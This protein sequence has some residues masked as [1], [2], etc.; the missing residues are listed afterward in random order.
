MK[1]VLY[2]EEYI[3]YLQ[4]KRYKCLSKLGRVLMLWSKGILP[5]NWYPRIAPLLCNFRNS[6]NIRIRWFSLKI[7]AS[8][9]FCGSQAQKPNRASTNGFWSFWPWYHKN[10]YN[11]KPRSF[12]P[13]FPSTKARK[14]TCCFRSSDFLLYRKSYMQTGKMSGILHIHLFLQYSADSLYLMFWY[15]PLHMSSLY[16]V[17]WA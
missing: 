8:S 5:P 9:C 13:G 10:A 2:S 7:A 12:L 1:H 16:I 4:L 15:V 17:I 3:Y 14:I 6:K 11:G